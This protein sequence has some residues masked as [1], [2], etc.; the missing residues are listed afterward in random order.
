M[1]YDQQLLD[2]VIG[3]GDSSMI[4]D[5]IRAKLLD[6]NGMGPTANPPPPDAIQLDGTNPALSSS[7]AGMLPDIMPKNPIIADNQQPP[8]A[9][10]LAPKGAQQI[11]SGA[12]PLS[13]GSIPAPPTPPAAP[14]P[15][16]AM[17]DVIKKISD[18][19]PSKDDIFRNQ[20]MAAGIGLMGPGN[21]GTQ[22][23]QGLQGYMNAGIEGQKA[24]VDQLSK[25]GTLMKG[26]D[27]V[28]RKRQN[29]MNNYFTK[30]AI[31]QQRNALA[32]ASMDQRQQNN[33]IKNAISQQRADLADS[34]NEYKNNMTRASDE[35]VVIANDADYNRLIQAATAL[36]NHPGLAGN[37]GKR[38]SLPTIPG[39]DAANAAADLNTL[40]SQTLNIVMQ[41]MKDRSKTGSAGIGRLLATEIPIFQANISS[42]DKSKSVEDAIKS[43]DAMIQFAGDAKQRQ[44]D[45]F[46]NKYSGD[47]SGSKADDGGGSGT[48][49]KSTINWVVKDGKLVQQ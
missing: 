30:L 33:D 4:P 23:Q 43:L 6:G 7:V 34:K 2:L 11:L 17:A 42:L 26:D 32:Q 18:L 44:R 35:N 13:P 36:K 14:P 15:G 47:Y 46:Q 41:N 16:A 1:A 31:G 45:A 22:V 5:D 9:N 48:G 25:L 8:A 19:T 20:L 39:T 12:S 3:T 37:F 28:E 27:D 40:R 10:P 49:D 24:G 38:G 29:D 21:L